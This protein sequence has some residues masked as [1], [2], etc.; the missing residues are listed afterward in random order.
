MRL[1]ILRAADEIGGN[2]I[3]LESQGK[4]ILLDL[5]LP[6]VAPKPDPSFLPDIPGLAEGGNPDLLGIVI[7]HPHQDHYG[8]LS[9]VHA[10]VPVYL[11]DGAKKLLEAASFFTPG[12]HIRQPVQTYLS[13][14]PFELGPFA[15]TPMLVDHSAYDAH[16]L[17][18][19]ADGKRVLYSGDFRAHGRKSQ[20]MESLFT[21]PPPDIDVLLME[22]TTLGRE[23]DAAPQTESELEAEIA[24]SVKETQGLVLAYFSA[25]NVD[26]LV[27]FYRAAIRSGRSLI[28]DVYTACL[29]DA[30][31]RPSLPS[32]GAENIRIFL[33]QRQK[34]QIIRGKG[35]DRVEPYR[36]RRIYP[37]EIAQHPERWLM[38][39]R[40]SMTQDLEVMNCCADGKLIYSLWPGYLDRGEEDIRGWSQRQRMRFEVQHTSGHAHFRDLKR[41]VEA[42]APK[43]LVP[44]HTL[45]PKRYAELYPT[46]RVLPDYT[47]LDIS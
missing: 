7:S 8:L 22:G 28:I 25:Q 33:P 5:G 34:R 16:A 10:D 23:T 12:A 46:F 45:H 38:M 15:I 18:I 14:K 35:F 24:T 41:F 21:R 1:R 37:D 42:M 47:W 13:G 20:Q 11:G 43:T 30:V 3:Q 6:L 4:T 19:E 17:L 32:T 36:S 44:I 2:C 40:G 39:F 29:L 31:E 26:R 27:T 9:C